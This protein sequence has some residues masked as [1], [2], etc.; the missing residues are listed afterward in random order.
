MTPLL[1]GFG[2]V[3]L[4]VFS[5]RPVYVLF[6]GAAGLEL[7]IGDDDWG[8]AAE[9]TFAFGAS[10]FDVHAVIKNDNANKI[11]INDFITLTSQKTIKSIVRSRNIKRTSLGSVNYLPANDR[12]DGPSIELPSVKRR[13]L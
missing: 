10:V 4:Q 3:F 12:C 1:F 9:T 8:E 11:V 13:V 6:A 2:S 5:S 7:E